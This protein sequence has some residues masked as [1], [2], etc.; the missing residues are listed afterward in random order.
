MPDLRRFVHHDPALATV[1]PHAASSGDRVRIVAPLDVVEPRSRGPEGGTFPGWL[2]PVN[3]PRGGRRAWATCQVRRRSCP[4]SG[5]L[6]AVDEFGLLMLGPEVAAG[7]R[8][9]HEQDEALSAPVLLENLAG[10]ADA[11]AVARRD[12]AT[13]TCATPVTA[14]RTA[15][16][17]VLDRSVC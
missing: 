7:L 9:G 6:A 8:G 10:M 2:V 4:R 12:S 16:A 13:G 5:L 17:S 1:R 3:R 14:D 15:A 11:M